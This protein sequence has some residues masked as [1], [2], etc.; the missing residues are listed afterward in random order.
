MNINTYPFALP[1]KPY[2]VEY[3]FYQGMFLPHEIEMIQAL[4]REDDIAAAEVS[5]DAKYDESLRKGSVLGI[6]V[7]DQNRWAYQKLEQIAHAANNERYQFDMTGF[8][9]PLQLA[10]YGVGDFFDWHLDFGSGNISNRKLSMTIQLTDP[11]EYEGGDLQFMINQRVVTAPREK[12]TIIVFP[13]F[14]LHRVTETTKGTR[15]SI[16]AW[17]SGPA[18]R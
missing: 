7:T 6:E 11:D 13:S 2:F 3:L 1:Q 8:N 12:G 14:I 9:E 10:R 4:W 5:S 17:V 18:F 16:V 15:E